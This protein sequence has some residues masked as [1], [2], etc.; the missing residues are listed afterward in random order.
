MIHPAANPALAINARRVLRAAPERVF[1]AWTRAEDLKRWFSPGPD[2]TVPIAEVDLR[3]GGR[4]RFGMQGP[5]QPLSVATGIYE[6]ITPPARLVFTW[7]WEEAGPT[8]PS[9]RVTV[10]F[11]PKDGGT[12]IILTHENFADA[13]DRDQHAAGWEGCLNMLAQWLSN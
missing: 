6:E 13:K 7:G 9:T 1:Q 2:F 10:E 8:A 4:Y 3:V 12:E 5:G 11:R